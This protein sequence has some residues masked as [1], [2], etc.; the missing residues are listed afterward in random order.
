MKDA[1]IDIK[2][3][4]LK[5]SLDQFLAAAEEQKTPAEDAEAKTDTTE[6]TESEESNSEE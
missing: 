2:D 3:E 1:K 5:T 4:D 6:E